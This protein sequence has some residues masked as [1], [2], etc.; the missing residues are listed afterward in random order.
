MKNGNMLYNGYVIE[1]SRGI[2]PEGYRV[3][4]FED[5]KTLLKYIG[6]KNYISNHSIDNDK[7]FDKKIASLITYSSYDPDPT[8]NIIF[9]GNNSTGF[10]AKKSKFIW[11]GGLLNNE[12]YEIDECNY[13]WTNSKAIIEREEYK[14]DKS[15]KRIEK[16][17]LVFNIG[18]CS[19]DSDDCGF[20]ELSG[21]SNCN[22]WGKNHGF[23]IRCIKSN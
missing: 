8:S 9:K 15:E 7:D 13:W 6:V 23:S 3:P 20:E 11:K 14:D 22:T 16:G 5:F 12:K 1:D 4:S 17:Y 18:Y 19:Q 2:C 10:S 21:K